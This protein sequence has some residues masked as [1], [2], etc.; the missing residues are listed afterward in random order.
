MQHRHA[1]DRYGSKWNDAESPLSIPTETF[2]RQHMTLRCPP[3][4]TTHNAAFHLPTVIGG[5]GEPA[6]STNLCNPLTGEVA[7]FFWT[8]N[9][10]CIS[11]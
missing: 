6:L 7:A 11:G 8:R 4:R 2:S 10:A 1:D 9:R 3:K 5:S